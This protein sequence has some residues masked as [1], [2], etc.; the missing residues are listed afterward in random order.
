MA[1]IVKENKLQREAFE[2]Y[3]ALGDER[4]LRKV[5][6]Q[7]D[8]TERSIAGWSRKFHWVD[9]VAQREIEEAKDG[10]NSGKPTQVTEVKTRYRI[11][12]NNL[13]AKASNMIAS[14]ELKIKNIPDLE[15][16]VKLDLLLMG[17]A[18]ESQSITGSTELSEA[19]KA[20]L[21]E[22]ATLLKVK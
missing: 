18:T 8:R 13:L 1:E 5:A 17:E 14:G 16:V 12:M 9:R 11:L 22:I 15:R 19:D 21:D 20:R 6:E 7:V 4:S 10:G 2:I 3:Y